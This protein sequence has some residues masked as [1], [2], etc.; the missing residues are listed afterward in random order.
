M[1][2]DDD[3]DNKIL[4][5]NERASHLVLGATRCSLSAW[6]VLPSHVTCIQLCTDR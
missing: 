4:V 6:L 5:A 2:H 1:A 3:D